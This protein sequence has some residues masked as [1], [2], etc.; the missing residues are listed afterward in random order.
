VVTSINNLSNEQCPLPNSDAAHA[1]KNVPYLE[2]MG[3]LLYSSI[4]TRI[5]IGYIV[6]RLCR[7]SCNPGRPHWE[8]GKRVLKYLISTK[9]DH[10]LY[11]A[12]RSMPSGQF[13]ET[14]T[15]SAYCDSNFVGNKGSDKKTN[16][17]EGKCTTGLIIMVNNNPVHWSSKKQTM[18]SLS[19]C[20]AELLALA[21]CTK[22]VI[23]TRN[24]IEEIILTGASNTDFSSSSSACSMPPSLIYCD[25]SSAVQIIKNDQ[26]SSRTKHASKEYHFVHDHHMRQ[27]INVQWIATDKQ[28]ADI[29]TK[30]TSKQIFHTLKQQLMEVKSNKIN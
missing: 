17:D 15:V 19:S 18:V 25:N 7:Y 12:S 8:A 13:N 9:K 3:S 20:E 26:T 24:L 16:T 27:D 22:E 29:L 21:A 11:K 6:S 5:D 14:I 4:I 1:M 2:L 30:P 23:W 28:L 10:L